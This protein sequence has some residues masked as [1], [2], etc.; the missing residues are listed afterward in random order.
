MY[1]TNEVYS[2]ILALVNASIMYILS[3][4][5]L[6]YRSV[7]A[8]SSLPLLIDPGSMKSGNEESATYSKIY[9]PTQWSFFG[10]D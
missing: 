9:D 8:D 10:K 1:M 7:V 5:G 3:L 6:Q 4:F 2:Y